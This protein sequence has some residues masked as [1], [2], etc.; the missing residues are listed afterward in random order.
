MHHV[1]GLKSFAIGL[2][3]TLN[4]EKNTRHE[5]RRI[6]LRDMTET[7]KRTK[8]CTDITFA[9]MD[10]G[11]TNFLRQNLL[12]FEIK[13]TPNCCTSFDKKKSFM[14]LENIP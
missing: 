9:I 8:S 11:R 4:Q 13:A 5:T 3:N 7:Y 10:G 1:T 6:T 2:R 14:I 12:T